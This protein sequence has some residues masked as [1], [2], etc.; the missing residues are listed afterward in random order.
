MAA[1]IDSHA[2][3]LFD[4]LETF[5]GRRSTRPL[6]VPVLVEESSR[7]WIQA[8]SAP[9]RPRGKMT[10]ARMRKIVREEKRRGPRVDRSM[11]ACSRVLATGARMFSGSVVVKSDEKTTYPKLA[12]T[13]FGSRR[14]THE[15]TSS[16]LARG[17]WNPLFPINHAENVARDHMGRLRRGSWLV[18]KQGCYLDLHLQMYMAH[19]NYVVRRFNEDPVSPAQALGFA[20]RRLRRGE[21]L[22]WRQD[23]GPDRS[24]HPLSS[25][26]ESV[27]QR[28]MRLAA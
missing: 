15:R 9:I 28:R 3:L 7:F 18:S 8:I 21:L 17:T 11:T 16:K 5:E 13:A 19:R 24:I 14:L 4:E 27:R 20:E 12:R 22:S 1:T 26:R 2:V 6:T 10:A 25:G 23:W